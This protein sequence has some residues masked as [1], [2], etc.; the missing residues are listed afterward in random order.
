MPIPS[1]GQINNPMNNPNLRQLINLFEARNPEIEYQETEKQVTAVL[2]SYN[3]QVYT[4]LAHKV[5]KI[6]KLEEEIK[7]LKEEVKQST[8]EDIEF[9]FSAEDAAKTRVIQ[10]LGFILQLSKDPE[11]TKT[12]KYKDI[13]A[14]L[15]TKLT[16]ELIVV[17]NQLKE[18]MI[19]TTQKAAGL[20][21]KELDEGVIGDL[22]K[23]LNQLVQNWGQ[24]YDQE[25]IALQRQASMM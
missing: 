4:K 10:T 1:P 5:Q 18:T 25:L 8:R 24:R 22:F 12:P 9:L 20:K 7:A 6:E 3:S 16:P 2:R 17:L 14:V 13:L 19:T 23:R 11:A 15:S 21:V